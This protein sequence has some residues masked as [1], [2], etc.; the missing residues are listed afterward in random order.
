MP[1]TQF[2]HLGLLLVT[3]AG[4]TGCRALLDGDDLD[5]H[6]G[7][8]GGA[9]ASTGS[10]G[11]TSSGGGGGDGPTTATSTGPGG[12][13]TSSSSTSTST[14]TTSTTTTSSTAS[15]GAG[16]GICG[17]GDVNPGEEC[18]DGGVGD[19]DGCSASCTFEGGFSCPDAIDVGVVLDETVVVATTTVGG[20]SDPESCQFFVAPSRFFRVTPATDG[21]LTAW[22]TGAGTSYAS[23]LSL[24][25]AC[26]ETLLCTDATSAT[27]GE[28]VSLPAEQGIPVWIQVTGRDDDAGD[29]TVEVTLDLGTCADP[30]EIHL[31][32][33]A[34]AAAE[35]SLAGQ[36]DD[37]VGVCGGSENDVAYRLTGVGATAGSV[38]AIV[39]D[40]ADV[41]LY[42]R[43]MCSSAAFEVDCANDAGVGD[44][45]TIAFDLDPAVDLVVDAVSAGGEVGLSFSAN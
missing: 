12:G 5:L 29:F 21:F 17:D 37:T 23:A 19:G 36:G 14:T 41:V 20:A 24:R 34:S 40:D 16:G 15:T 31:Q 25:T 1:R 32:P 26:D 43:T 8:G 18:D 44:A 39:R 10:D 3:L 33:G 45:E 9:G 28:V 7:Q 35:T 22:V 13:A 30:V 6:G 38:F 11:P 4:T 42:T 2:G 27:G